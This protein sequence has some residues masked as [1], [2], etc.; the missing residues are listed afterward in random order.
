MRRLGA[1]LREADLA[2]IELKREKLAFERERSEA[3]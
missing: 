1:H 2:R 3:E